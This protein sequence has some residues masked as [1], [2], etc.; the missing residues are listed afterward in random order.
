MKISNSISNCNYYQFI[1]DRIVS[2][3]LWVCRFFTAADLLPNPSPPITQRNIR[4]SFGIRKFN[5]RSEYLLNYCNHYTFCHVGIFSSRLG[6]GVT[7]TRRFT[8]KPRVASGL[9]LNKIVKKIIFVY[10]Y[11]LTSK[12][13]KWSFWGVFGHVWDP[14]KWR[15]QRDPRRCRR[16]QNLGEPKCQ[17]VSEIGDFFWYKPQDTEG[18]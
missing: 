17:A 7:Q 4:A 8:S 9:V 18:D 14:R 6:I 12:L 3:R 16:G 11:M 2:P 10:Q 15:V 13:E 5:K 1:Y